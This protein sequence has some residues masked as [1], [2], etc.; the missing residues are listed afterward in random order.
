MRELNKKPF[1]NI[2]YD[3]VFLSIIIP[4][5]NAGEY[6]S[7]CLSSLIQKTSYIYEIIVIDDGSSDNTS[8]IIADY[9]NNYSFINGI[10]QSNKGVSSARNAG[11]DKAKGDHIMFVDSDDIVLP[12]SLQKIFDD[13]SDFPCDM[14]SYTFVENRDGERNTLHFFNDSFIIDDFKTEPVLKKVLYNPGKRMFSH[15]VVRIISRE[16]MEQNNSKFNENIDLYEDCIFNLEY[17]SKIRT[18]RYID[19]PIYERRLH[20]DSLVSAHRP[21]KAFRYLKTMTC[22]QNATDALVSVGYDLKYECDRLVNDLIWATLHRDLLDANYSSDGEKNRIISDF[23]SSKDLSIIIDRLC[24]MNLAPKD[25]LKIWLLKNGNVW[26]F[27]F[28]REAQKLLNK[29]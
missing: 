22:I 19:E 11:I 28:K 24:L 9:C 20:D 21:E 3:N 2:G 17:I 15:T 10:L 29:L 14:L 7:A 26:I 27:E 25:R 4:A 16:V 13:Y 12:G 6:L 23:V 8:E 5:Y 1:D 18:F